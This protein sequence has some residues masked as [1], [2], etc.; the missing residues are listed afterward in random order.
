MKKTNKRE[1][2]RQCTGERDGEVEEET[3]NSAEPAE[4]DVSSARV[5]ELLKRASVVMARAA[6]GVW[7]AARVVRRRREGVE[8]SWLYCDD[9][10]ELVPYS[11]IRDPATVR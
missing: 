3:Q 5:A 8:V 2:E 1:R 6:E 10:D 4:P 9:G 7:G 11:L